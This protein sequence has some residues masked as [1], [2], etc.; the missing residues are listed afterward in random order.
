MPQKFTLRQLELFA[1]AVKCGQISA[2][3]EQM[4]ISQSAMTMAIY[5]L[6]ERVGAALLDRVKGGVTLTAQGAAFFERMKPLLDLANE[7]S[8]F[9]FHKRSQIE[10]K[11]EVASSYL[12]LGY[13]LIPHLSR[14]SQ[15]FSGIEVT[16]VELDRQTIEDRLVSGSL[17]IAVS[18]LTNLEKRERYETLALTSSR[19]RLWVGADHP[20][21]SKRH[22]TPADISRFTYIVP[23]VDDGVRF[24][25]RLWEAFGFRPA[26]WITTSSM[27]A[28]REMVA[29]N[30]G[31][32]IL[33]D[34]L[35]RSW[36]L[37]GGRLH[38]LPVEA[39]VP[40]IEI[41]LAWSEKT[42]LS[43]CELLFKDFMST[44]TAPTSFVP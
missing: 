12:V 2:A 18:V 39:P 10:G 20:L 19:R 5:N 21:L 4:N 33:S 37:D 25:H 40:G 8:R 30:V 3:A 34:I 41:G 31:V 1:A 29:V 27:E 42:G 16:P 11:L 7:T 9:P 38:A 13:Y 44:S 15:L 28:V 23:D 35:F 6:E 17:R 26:K 14:F 24:A 32:T 43:D 22:V 36:S